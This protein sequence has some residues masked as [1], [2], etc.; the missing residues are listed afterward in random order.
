[1]CEANARGCHY[2]IWK[3]RQT[4]VIT[5]L[6]ILDHCLRFMSIRRNSL[7][8]F[9][10]APLNAKHEPVAH[11]NIRWPDNDTT[12]KKQLLLLIHYFFYM[13]LQPVLRARVSS[14]ARSK[15]STR[16]SLL[17]DDK[18][19]V[20]KSAEL[21]SKQKTIKCKNTSTGDDKEKNERK[22]FRLYEIECIYFHA[23]VYMYICM[24]ITFPYLLRHWLR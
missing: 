15:T 20:S 21:Q 3:H 11:T 13:V 23:H 17:A 18:R 22:K 6:C 4:W 9:P 12:K 8:S 5:T 10:A 2:Q 14:A 19:P 7:T 16:W 1:M 24:I